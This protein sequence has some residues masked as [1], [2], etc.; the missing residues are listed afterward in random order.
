MRVLAR[1]VNVAESQ[2]Q[3]IDS[4]LDLVKEQIG[5]G[6][7]LRDAVRTHRAFRMIL[8]AGELVLLAVNSAAGR[9]EDHALQTVL[10]RRFD[11]IEKSDHVH[12]RVV[13]GIGDRSPYVHLRCEM[14]NNLGPRLLDDGRDC[15]NV[16]KIGLIE[17]RLR[18]HLVALAGG[19]IIQH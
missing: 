10:A 7:Q 16:A 15:G 11:Q 4:V 13:G 9:R 14:N 5:F 1:A 8:G 2:R 3:V 12:L 18:I 6:R 19:K 17:R